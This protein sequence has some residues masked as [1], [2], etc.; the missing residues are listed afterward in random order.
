MV[1]TFFTAVGGSCPGALYGALPMCPSP[2][3]LS[4]YSEGSAVSPGTEQSKAGARG[5]QWM[6]SG[7]LM[8]QQQLWVICWNALFLCFKLEI[9]ESVF[10]F[11]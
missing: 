5:M 11:L 3:G 1:V 10:C 6:M 8:G 4:S 2:P 7:A 9:L